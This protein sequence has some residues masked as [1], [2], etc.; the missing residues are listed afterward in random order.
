M[1]ANDFEATR[2]FEVALRALIGQEA[3]HTLV[4]VPLLIQECVTFV[5]DDFKAKNVTGLLVLGHENVLNALAG[6]DGVQF[7]LIAICSCPTLVLN[8]STLRP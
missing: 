2:Y 4:L 3:T 7:P 1:T 5:I 6:V 8:A